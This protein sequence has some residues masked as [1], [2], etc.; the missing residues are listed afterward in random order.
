MW[1]IPWWDI[2][3]SQE[4]AFFCTATVLVTTTL[5]RLAWAESKKMRLPP[6]SVFHPK[7][8][9]AWDI[10]F[11]HL[12]AISFEFCAIHSKQCRCNQTKFQLTLGTE[13]YMEV[14]FLHFAFVVFE[15][16]GWFCRSLPKSVVAAISFVHTDRN[17]FSSGC[18][19]H[20]IDLDVNFTILAVLC[21]GW[22]RETS[23]WWTTWPAG[24][25]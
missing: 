2:L 25:S 18:E 19:L 6:S 22:C 14:I 3:N 9:S 17:A 5:A 21:P 24:G 4:F 7:S 23:G 16:Y 13:I 12:C 1:V 10:P 11:I 15:K 8:L 20:H